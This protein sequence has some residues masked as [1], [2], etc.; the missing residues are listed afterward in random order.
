MFEILSVILAT[1]LCS[2]PSFADELPIQLIKL[3]PGFKISI[4]ADGIT[5]ARQLTLGENGTVFVG[6]R[7]QDKVYALVDQNH[8]G[9]ADQKFV[10]AEH[11]I[12]PNGVAFQ[13]GALYVAEIN[14]I[15][16]FDDIESQ[17]EQPPQPVIVNESL[18][19]DT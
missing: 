19:Q 14:R 5:N 13:N 17:L 18:P 9:Q 1:A 10:V 15:L 2:L 3:P 11:L 6:N 12:S 8:D 7:S 16:R 4:F